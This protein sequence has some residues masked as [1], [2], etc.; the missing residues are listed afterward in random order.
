[1][2]TKVFSLVLPVSSSCVR[3][4]HWVV[5]VKAAGGILASLHKSACCA[6]GGEDR[7]DPLFGP[8]APKVPR[9]FPAPEL[10]PGFVRQAEIC[11]VAARVEAG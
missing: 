4:R 2:S 1:M 5:E 7:L 3:S 9:Y 11:I 6:N 10:R 8:L